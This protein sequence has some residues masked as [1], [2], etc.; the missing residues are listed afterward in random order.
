MIG[1]IVE[2]RGGFPASLSIH[3]FY[4]KQSLCQSRFRAVF[5]LQHPSWHRLT[6]IIEQPE[7]LEKQ[8]Q[9]SI[10]RQFDST[11]LRSNIP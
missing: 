5:L 11:S 6:G 9:R 3:G 10:S 4:G 8:A 7:G 2:V 1:S